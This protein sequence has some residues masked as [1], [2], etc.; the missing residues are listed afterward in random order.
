MKNLFFYGGTGQ[1]V[2]MREVAETNGYNVVFVVDDFIKKPPWEFA[3][4]VR[5]DELL[6]SRYP[7]PPYGFVVTISNYSKVRDSQNGGERRV[8]I[9]NQLIGL[10]H[11]PA[12]LIHPHALV[13]EH[14]II[15]KNVQ[16]HAGAVVEPGCIIHNHCIINAG[17]ILTHDCY[18]EEGVEIFPGAILGGMVIVEKYAS[19]FAGATIVDRLIIG[20]KARVASGAVVINHVP[21]NSLAI[22]VPAE[23]K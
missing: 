23:I 12:T 3:A 1:A 19:V 17:A 4:L 18:I 8:E 21:A 6:D 13:S 16:I 7:I 2:V 15:G 11:T 10:G 20:S 5:S 14:T 22:G 9:A